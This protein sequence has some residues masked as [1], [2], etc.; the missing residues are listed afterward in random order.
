[1]SVADVSKALQHVHNR[2]D[3]EKQWLRATGGLAPMTSLQRAQVWA[4]LSSHTLS[5]DAQ[6]APVVFSQYKTL[7]KAACKVVDARRSEGG[8]ET[9]GAEVWDMLKEYRRVLEVFKEVAVT[10]EEAHDRGSTRVVNVSSG[11][12]VS[13]EDI[14]GVVTRAL[15]EELKALNLLIEAKL[16]SL[17]LGK[18]G[19]D[20]A[21]QIKTCLDAV[22]GLETRMSELVTN[23]EQSMTAQTTRLVD[24]ERSL[25][26]STGTLETNTPLDG[27]LESIQAEI[28]KLKDELS[29]GGYKA[30]Q[31]RWDHREKKAM[32]DLKALNDCVQKSKGLLDKTKHNADLSAGAARTAVDAAENASRAAKVAT[33]STASILQKM[34]DLNKASGK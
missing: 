10:T 31:D 9:P 5:M 13:A 12:G 1:M 21:D 18:L 30:L 19:V 26:P 14:K 29:K 11:G 33:D 8:C 7:Y 23:V 24:F 28:S 6:K 4:D 22:K 15:A 3:V 25:K 16:D 2:L 32:D 34:A 27:R 20:A 17:P